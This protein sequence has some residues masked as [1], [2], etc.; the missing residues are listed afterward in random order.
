M[1]FHLGKIEIGA[2]TPFN[3]FLPILKKVNTK[4]KKSSGNW[5]TID[6]QMFLMKMPAARPHEE[7]R[8]LLLEPIFFALRTPKRNVPANS[9][10]QICL[11]VDD[12]RPCGRVG[13]FE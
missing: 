13:I 4:I 9:I 1:A 8:R 3:Q 11:T 7:Y 2:R 6:Q 5:L 10:T 12:V